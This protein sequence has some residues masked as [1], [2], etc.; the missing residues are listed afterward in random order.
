MTCRH[1]V[2]YP[3]Q[4]V[5]RGTDKNG[6]CVLLERRQCASCRRKVETIAKTEACDCVGCEFRAVRT[7][8]RQKAPRAA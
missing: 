8:R 6:F 2:L 1:T 3:P 4:S 5:R 7:A